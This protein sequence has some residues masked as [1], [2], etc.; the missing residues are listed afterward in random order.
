LERVTPTFECV[1]PEADPI[2][3]NLYEHYVHDMSEWFSINVRADGAFGHDTSSLWRADVAVT[4]A[5]EG[6]ELAGFGIVSSAEKWLGKPAA[7]DIKDFFILRRFRHKG[8]GDALAKHLWDTSPAE[9]L[10]RVLAANSPA[11]S[12]WRRTVRS[13]SSGLY[14][15]RAARD[16]DRDWIQLRFDN[17]ATAART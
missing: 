1:G 7:R 17:T 13:Y 16:G 15:E 9:W 14:E 6:G 11:A 8:V 4:L 5:R 3:R 12:F 2:L 10:V